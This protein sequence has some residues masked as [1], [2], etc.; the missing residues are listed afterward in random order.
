M[1]VLVVNTMAPFIW[2]GAEALAQHLCENLIKA[3]HKSEIL[4]IPFQWEPAEKIPQQMLMVRGLDLDNVDRVIALKFPSYLIQ[5]PHKTIWLLH[6][7]RQAY[8][9]YDAGI[10]NLLSNDEM[11]LATRSFIMNAD[12][13]TFSN[14]Q[15][16]YTISEV[17]QQ[18]L[19]HYN[20][21][22]AKLLRHPVNDPELFKA[23]SCED[24]IFAG[25]RINDVKRQYLLLEALALTNSKT[26]LIIAGPP[27]NTADGH[28]LYQLAEKLNVKDRVVLD[29]RFLA[30]K[31]YVNY[32]NNARAVAYLPFEED[33]IGY[34]AMEAATAKKA[35]I[36][37]SDSGGVLGLAHHQQTGWV[38]E[39][40]PEALAEVMQQA[41]QD[42][43]L[44]IRLGE[45]A[46]QRWE[47][48]EIT[49]P[50]T[51]EALLS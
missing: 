20:G 1:N 8:D 45:Q 35:L 28:K 44:A 16:V 22:H 36:A 32:I 50:K 38:V 42:K 48:M 23:Q 2:G 15:R 9:M 17:T 34:V 6:Q 7:Y 21:L 29:I 47:K 24:Y 18:R 4:N 26:R 5:H 25:G 11:T 41:C 30:R 40:S 37:T 39:P 51:V 49:W 3:G 10:S 27:D 14:I 12:N 19:A 31:E 33:S 46:F 43:K 13:D